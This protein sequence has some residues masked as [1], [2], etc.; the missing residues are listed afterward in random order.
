MAA[1]SSLQSAHMLPP[2][3]AAAPNGLAAPRGRGAPGSIRISYG[4]IAP[5]PSLQARDFNV[6]A[7]FGASARSQSDAIDRAVSDALWLLVDELEAV[8]HDSLPALAD[9]IS[10]LLSSAAASAAEPT[11]ILTVDEQA[12]ANRDML[13]TRS[14]AMMVSAQPAML[15]LDRL[16]TTVMFPTFV[17]GDE[18]AA[19]KQKELHKEMLILQG[20]YTGTVD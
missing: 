11:S 4:V 13:G 18:T 14:A 17:S 1:K 9:P 15:P 10:H 16:A 8:E 3:G 12:G 19:K 2:R 6:G 5:P 20:I 7:D